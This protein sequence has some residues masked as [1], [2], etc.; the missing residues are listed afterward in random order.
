MS[1]TAGVVGWSLREITLAVQHLYRDG[2][3]VALQ[4]GSPLRD[5]GWFPGEGVGH[6]YIDVGDVR[7]NIVSVV[8]Y[9]ASR[10]SEFG[11]A[12]YE[13]ARLGTS[14][15]RLT[16]GGRVADL[17]SGLPARRA[18]TET[19]RRADGRPL[20]ARQVLVLSAGPT[21]TV[22]LAA[23]DEQVDVSDWSVQL[24]SDVPWASVGEGL[25]LGRPSS[26]DVTSVSYTPRGISFRA[27]DPAALMLVRRD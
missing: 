11:Y 1:A 15:L 19:Y 10:T 6:K 3:L 9:R 24:G 21:C 13:A 5:G 22:Q 14:L 25:G 18:V 26:A 23:S 27:S 17:A 8:D 2:E 4:V 12:V 7:I 16:C 20:P